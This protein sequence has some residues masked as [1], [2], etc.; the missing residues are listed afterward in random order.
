MNQLEKFTSRFWIITEAPQ[1]GRGD[2]F[3]R[4]LLHPTHDHAHMGSFYYDPNARGVHGLEDCLGNFTCEPLLN[5]RPR[6]DQ[7]QL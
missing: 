7:A 2:G 1:H 5:L 6:K 3:T 4:C